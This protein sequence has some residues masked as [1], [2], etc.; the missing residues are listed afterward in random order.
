MKLTVTARQ[1]IARS[2]DLSSLPTSRADAAALRARA[3]LACES[4]AARVTHTHLPT[5]ESTSVE[6]EMRDANSIGAI[7]TFQ[8]PLRGASDEV[9]Q[10]AKDIRA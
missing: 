3:R 4:H 10:L 2:D 8:A 7:R 1:R 5:P 9:P 6:R